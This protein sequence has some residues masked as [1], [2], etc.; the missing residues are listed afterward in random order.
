VAFTAHFFVLEEDVIFVLVDLKLSVAVS[1]LVFALYIDMSPLTFKEI[2]ELFEQLGFIHQTL[3]RLFFLFE[4][5]LLKLNL[6]IDLELF[7]FFG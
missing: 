2:F 1:C 5:P 6:F 4:A 7:N 3:S